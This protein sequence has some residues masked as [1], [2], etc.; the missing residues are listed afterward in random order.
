MESRQEAP[1]SGTGHRRQSRP[2][3]PRHAR[4]GTGDALDLERQIEVQDTR[5]PDIREAEES[6]RSANA[7]VGVGVANFFPQLSLTGL[8]GQ[9][10]PGNVRLH[11]RRGQCLEHLGQPGRSTLPGRPPARAISP[12][13]VLAAAVFAEWTI[14]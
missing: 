4:V 5:R 8:F 10:K 1:A 3:Q 7:Q 6:L 12:G 9:V 13:S 14:L 11:L 2:P